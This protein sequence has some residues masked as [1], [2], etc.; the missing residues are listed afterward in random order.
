MIKVLRLLVSKFKNRY[1]EFFNLQ[2]FDKFKQ[3]PLVAYACA[4][5]FL[6]HADFWLSRSAG[7]VESA[8]FKRFA[9]PDYFQ[10]CE[11]WLFL[12]HGI[13]QISHAVYFSF[14]LLVMFAFVL[15]IYKKKWFY[16]HLIFVFLI[17]NQIYF[18]FLSGTQIAT[19]FE[20]FSLVTAI[21]MAI[22]TSRIADLRLTWV[23]LYFLAGLVKIHESWIVGTYFS[24]LRQGL[25]LFPDWSLPFLTN[26]VI[27]AETC[28]IWFLLSKNKYIRL[29]IYTYFMVFHFYS[30]IYVNWFYPLL[31]IP[32]L[33]VLFLD[34]DKNYQNF[35]RCKISKQNFLLVLILATINLMPLFFSKNNKLDNVAGSLAMNMFDSNRQSHSELKITYKNTSKEPKTSEAWTSNSFLR[36]WPSHSLYKIKQMCLSNNE[37]EKIKWTMDISM[38][39]EPYKRIVDTEDA[40]SLRFNFWGGNDWINVDGPIIGYP[41]KNYYLPPSVSIDYEKGPLLLPTQQIFLTPLQDWIM[42]NLKYFKIFYGFLAGLMIFLVLNKKNRDQLNLFF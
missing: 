7:T 19:A 37:I 29:A 40:C 39:G 31:A 3:L 33:T 18:S 28:G 34:E 10:N 4:F 27:L 8:Q 42:S 14:L 12:R 23:F 5:N 16:V 21:V 35:S 41:K 15:S 1:T 24:T 17:I 6:I 30:A 20:Y 25:Y 2:E 32:T 22:S 13:D 9:C 36:V 26:L 11:N 38:N